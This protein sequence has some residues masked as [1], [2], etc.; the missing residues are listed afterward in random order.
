MYEQI[1]EFHNSGMGQFIGLAS[2]LLTLLALPFFSAEFRLFEKETP[3]VWG[4]ILAIWC[5][6]VGTYFG[7]DKAESILGAFGKGL[8]AGFFLLFVNI[9][10]TSQIN[11]FQDNDPCHRD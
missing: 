2:F 10:I 6:I 1:V 7:L 9:Y 8:F 5:F 11:D 3:K 4:R